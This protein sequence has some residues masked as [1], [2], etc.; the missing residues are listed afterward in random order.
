MAADFVLAA[1]PEGSPGAQHQHQQLGQASQSEVGQG[2]IVQRLLQGPLLCISRNLDQNRMRLSL[3][4]QEHL[5]KAVGILAVLYNLAGHEFDALD[6][7]ETA[8][9]EGAFALVVQQP[10]AADVKALSR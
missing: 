3:T 2:Q 4:L 10:L 1:N 5:E 8:Y 6:A 9:E 7:F